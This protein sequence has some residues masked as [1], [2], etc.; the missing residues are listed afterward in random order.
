MY[1]SKKKEKHCKNIKI[2]KFV[3]EKNNLFIAYLHISSVLQ[4]LEITLFA[5]HFLGCVACFQ[6]ML[7]N[8][9]DFI[10]QNQRWQELCTHTH[11]LMHIYLWH[12][13]H[14]LI[15]QYF[16]SKPLLIFNFQFYSKSEMSFLKIPQFQENISM[17]S[18]YS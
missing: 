3:A 8:A 12:F 14:R 2:F 6:I 10:S 13:L 15:G 17:N 1:L 18:S 9:Q 7:G 5:Q 11:T 16:A 4:K